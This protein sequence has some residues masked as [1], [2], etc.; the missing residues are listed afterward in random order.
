MA[1]DP[2]LCVGALGKSA[3]EIEGFGAPASR[4][5][6]RSGK[7]RHLGVEGRKCLEPL[8]MADRLCPATRRARVRH[9]G[10]QQRSKVG[11]EPI[12][13]LLTPLVKSRLAQVIAV[14]KVAGVNSDRVL[15]LSG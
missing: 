3:Q 14:Q 8:R 11:S 9:R 7:F 1:R 12:P 2:Q 6:C 5:E 13:L 10:T 4:Q 15:G